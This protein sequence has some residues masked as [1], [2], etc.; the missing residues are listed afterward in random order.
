MRHD[1]SDENHCPMS[2]SVAVENRICQTDALEVTPD[3][4]FQQKQSQW[5]ISFLRQD[6]QELVL[7]AQVLHGWLESF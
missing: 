1:N 6:W 3:G 2:G 5:N 4:F 7:P